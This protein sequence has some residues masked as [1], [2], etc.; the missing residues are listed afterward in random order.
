MGRAKLVEIVGSAL[1]AL[2][3]SV[4]AAEV[5][6]LGRSPEVLARVKAAKSTPDSTAFRDALG[7]P[8]DEG[9]ERAGVD[10]KIRGRDVTR[11]RQ[12]H[13][14]VPVW[15]HQIIVERDSTGQVKQLRGK[16]VAG[17]DRDITRVKPGIESDQVVEAM[18]TRVRKAFGAEPAVFTTAKAELVIYTRQDG[19]AALGYAVSML[20]DSPSGGH[21]SRPVFIVDAFSGEVLFQYDAIAYQ[22]GG[23]SSGCNLLSQTNIS[24]NRNAWKYFSVTIPQGVSAGTMMTVRS[25]G[26]SGDADLYV[27][28]GSQPTPN[29]YNCR[30]YLTGNVENCSITVN[31]GEIWYFGLNAYSAFSGVALR[32]DLQAPVSQ[33]GS[34]PG[35]NGNTGLY[36]YGR[37]YGTLAVASDATLCTM[38]NSNVQT[39]HLYNGT[40]GTTPFTYNRINNDCY[41]ASDA[42]NGA[43]SPLND[44]HYFGGVIFAMYNAYLGEPPL[45][46][47]LSMRVHYST[48]YDN[49]FWDGAAMTFGDG[50]SI[51]YPLVSI[52]VAAHEVSHGFTEQ[53]SGLTYDGESGG[54]NESYSDIAGEAAEDYFR[55]SADF[56]VGADIAKNG[57]FLRSMSNPPIDG[58]SIDNL[59]DYKNGLDVHYSSGI[60]NKAFYLLA[61]TSGWNVRKAFTAFANANRY[62]WTPDTGFADGAQ[63]VVDEAVDLGLPALDVV[64]A[65]AAVGITGLTYIVIPGTPVL[66][67]TSTTA[68]Q[69]TLSWNDAGGETSYSLRRSTT[70]SGNLDASAEIATPGAGVTTFTDSSLTASTTYYYQ[71]V[72]INKDAQSASAVASATTAAPP[73]C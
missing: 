48:D 42:A 65:F 38:T 17:L 29:A 36:Y 51:F 46:F 32:A 19:P 5:K 11:Y 43:Y 1:L 7:L 44:A 60:Y 31:S 21:P 50:A 58:Q 73:G 61:T 20:A 9:L 47:Q 12:T 52:D 24:A 57:G 62:C 37:E 8:S 16:L 72:A 3:A 23:C 54:I 71:L 64:N 13:H 2:S 35:G 10:D 33:I 70:S 30:P 14:G 28:K 63:C 56:L 68:T 15:G 41:Q 55:G 59:A 39:V 6:N 67:V 49:A 4:G 69:V 40:D 18:K 34:G 53:H 27:R 22:Q 45:T 26:G 25:S 66:S